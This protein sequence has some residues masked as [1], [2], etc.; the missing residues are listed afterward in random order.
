MNDPQQVLKVLAGR[1]ESG[2]VDEAA[3]LYSRLSED[4]GY[5]LVQKLP[6]NPTLR[7]RMAKMFFI[8]KDY[9]KAALVFEQAGELEK[10][11]R[12][13]E[14]AD[15]YG[16]AAEMF[17]AVEQWDKAAQNYERNG[18]YATAADLYRTVGDLPRAAANFEKAVN[19][20][21]A[22]KMYFE[23]G[24]QDKAAELLQRIG[25][26]DPN[27][28]EATLLVNRILAQ[29]GYR[30]IA[31]RKLSGLLDERGLVEETLDVALELAMEMMA[32][33]QLEEA[34]GWLEKLLEI[35]FPYKNAGDLLKQIEAGEVEVVELTEEA[36]I[37]DE[38]EA[39]EIETAEILEDMDPIAED[40]PILALEEGFETIRDAALFAE[41]SLQELKKF[42]TLVEPVT[43]EAGETIIEQDAPG[44]GLIIVADGDVTVL[45]IDEGG[46]EEV[47]AELGPGAH[48]GEMSLLDDA[49]TSARVRAAG[50]RVETYRM[51]KE[52]FHR[53][54][55]TDDRLARKIY[56]AFA[57]TLMGRLR[58]TNQ[59]FRTFKDR[60]Q[61]E[62]A[63]L[64]GIKG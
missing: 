47:L 61:E 17:A 21:L 18:N 15:D 62:M 32:E 39:D 27:Y 19:N 42:W 50:D 53:L 60:Q 8:A 4:V 31:I 51:P 28:V 52:A 24:K 1:L 44:E 7:N 54:I 16:M 36:D 2:E 14:K 45:R 59:K 57:A 63:D 30:S 22:G 48:L 41:L 5:R 23:L 35:R 49:P 12:L 26:E 56:Q 33:G 40:A 29:S 11:G 20:F 46:N 43:Y 34:K 38:G 3:K 58:E 13:Y 6:P 9:E 10:A 37:V 55:E 64:F 25:A